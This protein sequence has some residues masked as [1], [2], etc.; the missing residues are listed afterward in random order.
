M[1]VTQSK[2]K[3]SI[4]KFVAKLDLAKIRRNPFFFNVLPY[5]CSSRSRSYMHNPVQIYIY[6][7]AQCFAN[8]DHFT[9]IYLHLNIYILDIYIYIYIGFCACVGFELVAIL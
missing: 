2:N 4:F 6:F 1:C 7:L 3:I 9:S 5:G 8:H